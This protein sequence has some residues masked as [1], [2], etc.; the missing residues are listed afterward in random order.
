MVTVYCL[1]TNVLITNVC[2]NESFRNTV[3]WSE[4]CNSL[5]CSNLVWYHFHW[6]ATIDKVT[7]LGVELKLLNILLFI[8]QLYKSNLTFTIVY[9]HIGSCHITE[10]HKQ[11][12]WY[13][14]SYLSPFIL[15]FLFLFCRETHFLSSLLLS[16]AL[17]THLFHW[18]IGLEW[19]KV[20]QS[21]PL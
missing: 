14:M 8:G 13:S 5:F 10:M 1:V 15:V 2:I 21:G 20:N 19:L 17:F 11:Q 3:Y 12:K 16:S 18:W 4:T 7:I 9:S 6:W